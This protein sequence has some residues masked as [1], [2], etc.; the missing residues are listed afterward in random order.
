MR[1]SASKGERGGTCRGKGG[2]EGE[3]KGEREGKGV[4]GKGLEG[5]GVKG[6]EGQGGRVRDDLPR[7]G[8]DSRHLRMLKRDHVRAG[9]L[10]HRMQERDHGPAPRDGAD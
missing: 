10:H 2:V 5:K 9:H 7:E 4:E 3:G 8:D 1:V 6:V